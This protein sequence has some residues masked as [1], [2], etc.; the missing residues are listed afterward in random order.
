MVYPRRGAAWIEYD[1]APD[2][3][4]KIEDQGRKSLWATTVIVE[5]LVPPAFECSSFFILRPFSRRQ[6]SGG[7]RKK[8]EQLKPG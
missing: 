8:S 2:L 7:S 5:R 6:S 4:R 3:N 1:P